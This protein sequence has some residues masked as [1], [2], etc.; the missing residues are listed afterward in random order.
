MHTRYG[1]THFHLGEQ[2]AYCIFDHTALCRALLERSGAR[3]LRAR[4]Q[5]LKDNTVLTSAGPQRAAALIDASGWPAAMA[6]KRRPELANPARLTPAIEADI[7]GSGHGI[8]FYVDARITRTGYG[9]VFPAGNELRVGVG[10]YRRDEDLKAALQRFLEQLGVK[11]RPA[12]G[13]MIPSFERPAVVD[14]IFMAGDAGGHCLPLTA[15]GIRFA[16]HYGAHAGQVV[17]RMLDGDIER[18][19]AEQLHRAA[20]ARLG[21]TRRTLRAVQRATGPTPDLAFHLLARLLAGRALR[22]PFLTRYGYPAPPP[23]QRCDCR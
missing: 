20:V 19:E 18:E 12:R 8:H 10:T 23:H 15:E 2:R 1:A 13:G 22:T 6:S 21:R 7:P 16:L 9:W 5:G 3:V 11:G 14:G 17:R 4:I